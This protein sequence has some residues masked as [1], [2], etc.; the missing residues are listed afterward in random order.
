MP[1]AAK[2]AAML[3]LIERL[4]HLR[5]IGINPARGHAVHQARIAQ[6]VREAGRVTVQHVA[7]YKRQRRQATLLAVSLDLATNLT[8]QAM[9][10]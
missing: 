10:L 5:A 9:D 7:G 4:E 6:L 3:G 8:D 2:P 1:E